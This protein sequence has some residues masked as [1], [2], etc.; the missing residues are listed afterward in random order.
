MKK[1]IHAQTGKATCV[2]I[3]TQLTI[4]PKLKLLSFIASGHIVVE[5]W[6]TEGK[7]FLLDLEIPYPQS[8]KI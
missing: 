5:T 7:G 1:P 8:Q 6:E 4:K 2:E 3:T